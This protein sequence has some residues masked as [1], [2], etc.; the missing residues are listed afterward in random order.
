MTCEPSHILGPR[1]IRPYDSSLLHG[2]WANW[3]ASRARSRRTCNAPSASLT[4][5]HRDT[6]PPHNARPRSRPIVPAWRPHPL[7]TLVGERA[8]EAT[9]S[10]V[11]FGRD[12]D[13]TGSVSATDPWSSGVN[14]VPSH[15]IYQLLPTNSDHPP[16]TLVLRPSHFCVYLL[17]RLEYVLQL[18]QHKTC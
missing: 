16:S 8:G 17:V 12:L 6:M 7:G 14:I 11:R 15:L 5:G 10:A 3:L 9:R 4:N 13:L 2:V 1:V 18:V